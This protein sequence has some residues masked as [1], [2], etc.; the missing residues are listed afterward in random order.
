MTRTQEK[1][2]EDDIDCVRV[3]LHGKEHGFTAEEVNRMRWGEILDYLI[4]ADEISEERKK[5]REK[6]EEEPRASLMDL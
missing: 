3:I 2:L 6:D 1:K 5:S 4:T